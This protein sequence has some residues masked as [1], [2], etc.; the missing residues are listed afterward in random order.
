M[1]TERGIQRA[2]TKDV[3]AMRD[4][5]NYKPYRTAAQKAESRATAHKKNGTW[6]SSAPVS[7]HPI[8]K[9]LLGK[10]PR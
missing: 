3:D 2:K 10:S 7:R 8:R 4:F 1:I 5:N 9:D 6:V